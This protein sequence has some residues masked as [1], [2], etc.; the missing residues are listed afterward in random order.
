MRRAKLRCA[1]RI[2]SAPRSRFARHVA[3][4]LCRAPWAARHASSAVCSVPRGG[5][6]P[7]SGATASLAV[8]WHG[9]GCPR[10]VARGGGACAR[11]CRRRGAFV[12]FPSRPRYPKSACPS[13][14]RAA[15]KHGQRAVACCQRPAPRRERGLAMCACVRVWLGA[16]GRLAA[17]PPRRASAHAQRQATHPATQQHRASVPVGG[18][19]LPSQFAH[20]RAACAAFARRARARG[21]HVAASERA[22]RQAR[23]VGGDAGGA[24]AAMHQLACTRAC[25][26]GQADSCG[27]R[28]HA[29]TDWR[30][31][32]AP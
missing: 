24:P 17:P 15:A 4:V 27:V 19:G 7:P 3:S 1:C 9:H 18:W 21:R 2:C 30:L 14:A 25:C 16:G 10:V 26:E 28:T 8:G 29:L 13:C 12:H 20:A 23:R 6:V 22:T 5:A 11:A 32:S 31:K